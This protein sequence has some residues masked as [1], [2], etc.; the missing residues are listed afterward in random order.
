MTRQCPQQEPPVDPGQ[1]GEAA[2]E[3]HD[4]SPGIVDH[5]E[6]K[7][8]DAAG[9]LAEDA[10]GAARFEFLDAV[11]GEPHDVGE[12]FFADR[13]LQQLGDPRGVPASPHMQGEPHQR[14]GKHADDNGDQQRPALAGKP[15]GEAG[16]ERSF[17]EDVFDDDFGRRRGNEGEDGGER[18][19]DQGQRE[20]RALAA[21]QFQEAGDQLPSGAVAAFFA[22]EGRVA[23]EDFRGSLRIVLCWK[24]G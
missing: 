3:L 17:A 19:R 23:G 10:G 15:V 4:G 2:D 11:Q 8:A 5:A 22:G 12:N 13:Q 14:N 21:E 6:D 20:R 24:R 9:V 1:D 18:E 16:R 7:F